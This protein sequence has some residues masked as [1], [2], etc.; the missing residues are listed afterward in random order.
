[1]H[2]SKNSS[3]SGTEYGEISECLHSR[4]WWTLPA[5]FV[6]C[7]SGFIV[8]LYYE[9]KLRLR[10]KMNTLFYNVYPATRVVQKVM[11]YFFP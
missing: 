2:K 6:N 11:P 7:I 8:L 3:P 10:S 5:P 4:G 1:M 9:V